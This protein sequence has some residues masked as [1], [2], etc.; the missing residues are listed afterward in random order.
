MMKYYYLLWADAIHAAKSGHYKND[1]QFKT[2]F[3]MSVLMFINVK[4]IQ[5]WFKMDFMWLNI[6]G[7]AETRHLQSPLNLINWWLPFALINYYFIFYKDKWKDI[8]KKYPHS[9]KK[10]IWVYFPLTMI[11][12]FGTVVFFKLL[13]Y[14]R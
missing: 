6:P 3:A 5:A 8:E 9:N 1:W 2:G 10:L 7:W 13:G 4:T 12:G 14:G 11:L